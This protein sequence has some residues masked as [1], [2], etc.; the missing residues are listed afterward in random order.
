MKVAT[1]T[2]NQICVGVSWGKAVIPK[3]AY[4]CIEVPFFT[5]QVYLW[6]VNQL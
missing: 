5:I 4:F 6:K 3:R 1:Y 2:S